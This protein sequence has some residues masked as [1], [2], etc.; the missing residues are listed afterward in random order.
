ME[1]KKLV[2]S[3]R[4][5]TIDEK[6]W[7]EIA[8]AKIVHGEFECQSDCSIG[9]VRKKKGEE[10]YVVTLLWMSQWGNVPNAYYGEVLESIEKVKED[11]RRQYQSGEFSDQL[12][13]DLLRAL[14]A[15]KI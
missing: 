1:L 2:L 5:V 15:E 4:S 12:V 10:K 8:R 9:V 13:R 11:L 14:P 6:E 7:D 3:D